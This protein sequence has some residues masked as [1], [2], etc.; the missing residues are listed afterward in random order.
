M[1]GTSS[2]VMIFGLIYLKENTSLN[3]STKLLTL[4][5]ASSYSIYLIHV[6]L[7]SILNRIVLKL[8]VSS[9]LHPNLLFLF[10]GIGAICGGV[11]MHL[12][13]EKPITFYLRQKFLKK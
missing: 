9:Y 8:D 10:L 2:A 4:L 11:I 13:F 6:P 5:G 12:V 1:Y 3:Q 7:L